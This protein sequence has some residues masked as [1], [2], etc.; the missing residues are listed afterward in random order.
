MKLFKIFFS[1]ITCL[2][3]ISFSTYAQEKVTEVKKST[4]KV[5]V[6]GKKY[7]IHTV[8][9]GE[10]LYSISK[11]YQ[12]ELKD[13]NS[14]NLDLVEGLKLGQAIKIP[15]LDYPRE[16]AEFIYHKIAKKETLYSIS[17][18]YN[19]ELKEIVKHNPEVKDGLKIDQIIK[20]PKSKMAI[21]DKLYD[22]NYNTHK[23]AR[24]QTLYSISKHYDVKIKELKKMNPELSKKSLQEGQ[25]IR[26][27]KSIDEMLVVEKDTMP[28]DSLFDA[29]VLSIEDSLK[30]GC[31]TFDYSLTK[32]TF[33]VALMLPFYV[34]I[35]D[36]LQVRHLLK[37]TE[38]FY[39]NTKFLEFY[40]GALIALEAIKKSGVAVDLH[41][42]DTKKNVEEV[43]KITQ[44][45]VFATLDLIIGPVY[46][47]TL[48]VVADSAKK[49]KIKIV[50]PLSSKNKCLS[51]NP[52]MF[53]VIP[54]LHTQMEG[55]IIDLSRQYDKNIL[56]VHNEDIREIDI[57]N[58]YKK[59]L[60]A[61]INEKVEYSDTLIKEIS[62][63]EKG[64]EGVKE[65]LKNDTLNL[66]VCPSSNRAFV[67]ELMTKLNLLAQ[68]YSIQVKGMSVWAKFDNIEIEYYHKL[69]LS[70]FSPYFVDYER[71]VVKDFILKYRDLYKNE[72]SRYAYQGYDVLYYFLN[73][74][75]THGSDFEYCLSSFNTELL[76]SEYKFVKVGQEGG[77]ENRTLSTIKYTKD[78]N[79][80]KET[81]VLDDRD[82]KE[83]EAKIEVE[84]EAPEVNGIE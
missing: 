75:K 12:V 80:V 57:I 17:K 66:I 24:K 5:M 46:S 19:I 28:S 81:I 42:Y 35:N 11:A 64:I 49:H 67:S 65:A 26:I 62:Y 55:S 7:Y 47:A 31:D 74:L 69:E 84:E 6:D 50:S 34:D 73:A 2:I 16:T 39:P 4:E 45:E 30:M 70:I 38:K 54:E 78:Y 3:F 56:V 71:Q 27:P 79:V 59:R 36:T 33:K 10:T 9:A 76:Q 83:Q 25:L 48:N 23:V 20:L 8:K 51:A 14:A 53:Q 43:K 40:E 58:T 61:L 52:Y 32:P 1:A 60:L 22:G 41:V 15:I 21:E 29:T 63:R 68:D 77:F 37:G 44:T 13:I 18:K 72:P 82:E